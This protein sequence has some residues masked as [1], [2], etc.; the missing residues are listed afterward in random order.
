ML[1]RPD[2]DAELF[3]KQARKVLDED[4]HYLTAVTRMGDLKQVVAREA[5]FAANGI[6]L[7]DKGVSIGSGM[8]EHL[9]NH[10]LLKPIDH[11]LE[12]KGGVCGELL[13][14]E[15][16]RLIGSEP[17]LQHLLGSEQDAAAGSE[18]LRRLKLPDQYR[19]K[20]TVARVRLPWLFEHLLT[21]ALI[22]FFLAKRLQLSEQQCATTM[23]AGLVHDIGELHTD[24]V[25][26]D[27]RHRLSAG[28][29]C[30]LNVHPI[31]GYLIA[32]ELLGDD[33]DV[34]TA[35]LQHHEKLDGSG[36]PYR[37]Q[38]RALGTLARI[39]SVAEVC[40]SIVARVPGRERLSTWM[41]LN[42]QKFDPAMIALL[43][44]GLRYQEAQDVADDIRVD[45]IEATAKLLRSWSEYCEARASGPPHELDFLFERMASLRAMLLQFGFDPDH[46]QYMQSLM[47]DKALSGELG[48]AFDEVRWQVTD[49]QREA[50]RRRAAIDT[51]LPGGELS[52]LDACLE[53][54]DC[55]L[56]VATPLER[57]PMAER[58][59]SQASP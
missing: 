36:Y 33:P 51:S 57:I 26:L 18:A 52:L 4:G 47:S 15:A 10:V 46:P 5:V 27:R 54:I 40:A 42:H 38:G 22:G 45:E 21:V 7:I 58:R 1:H 53:E 12:V 41:R 25:L 30:H 6:K 31:T 56:Q 17:Y 8:R 43:Q 29:L 11:S 3:E 16:G 55:Y 49:I 14:Q 13:A 34:A 50:L 32:K 37:L 19:F 2:T 23:I 24:P 39:L 28:E 48:A 9:L 20:L 59:G 35:V 44:Q